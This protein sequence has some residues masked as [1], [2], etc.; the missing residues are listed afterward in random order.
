MLEKTMISGYKKHPFEKSRNS[1]Q[2][3]ICQSIYHW[4]NDCPNKVKEEQFNHVKITF[5]TQ[6]IHKC[7]IETFEVETLNCT[8]LDSGGTNIACGK[9][10][11]DSYLNTLTEKDAQKVVEESCSNSFRF[12]DGNSKTS[13][14][15]MTVPA[16]IGNED[17]MIKTDVTNSDLP[18]LLSK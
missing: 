4:A 15:Y 7:Y 11:L 13:N 8:V 3:A 18:L 10:C 2:C 9:A 16:R 17:I 5:F 14:K 1:S 6:D 12:G